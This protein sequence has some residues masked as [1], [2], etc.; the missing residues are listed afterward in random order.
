MS[1]TI[2][3]ERRILIW[4]CVLIA[5]NQLGFGAIVPALPLYAR[6]FGVPVSAVGMAV[7]VYGLARFCIAVPTG[8]TADRLGRRPALALGG[9]LSAAGNLWCAAA[10][11]YP[12][13]IIARFVAGA[14]AGVVVTVGQIMLADITRPEWR[15]RAI[16]IYQ[17]TFIF[18]V[19]VGP[20]PGGWLA[21]A[22]GLH[23]PFAACGTASLIASA[24]A[25]FAVGE[26]RD[27]AEGRRKGEDIPTPAFLP[28]FRMLAANT[29]FMLVGLVAFA[30]AFTRTGGIFTIVPLLGHLRL[31]LDITEIGL[32][33]M[34]GSVAGLLAA[35]PTGALAD[36]Y[37][38]KTVIVPATLFSGASM[39]LF[40]VAPSYAVYLIACALWSL[41]TS[42]GGAA[43]AAYAADNAPPG[44]NAAAMSAFR[45]LGDAG[46]VAGPI[47]LGLLV[48]WSGADGGLWGAAAMLVLAGLA[49]ARFAPESHRG[50]G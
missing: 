15:G 6:A 31:D 32:G 13:F 27:M 38:R 18:A 41:A 47:L 46:Y 33:L 44:M 30:N 28:Q 40:A 5:V 50:R 42:V 24:V 11:G 49:F 48:D 43:P 37:G 14:G 22:W 21:E 19:G 29:G 23:A 34:L 35:W 45:M 4:M 8:R 20:L 2:R 36:R 25:W 16:S 39:L 3:P 7:A 26:T 10:T 1:L 17:G 9:L 12:E